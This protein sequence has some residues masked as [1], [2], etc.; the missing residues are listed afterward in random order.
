MKED[1][2]KYIDALRTKTPSQETKIRALSGGNQQKIVLGKELA[3][4]PKVILFDEPTRGIDVEAKRE[5]Y[6][7]MHE[8]A[9]QGVAVIMNSSDMMEVIGMSSRVIVMYEGRISG[10]LQKEELSEELIMQ[11]GMGMKKERTKEET[12]G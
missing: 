7:I 4:E 2:Q 3:T 6:Q 9:A 5:F 11:F 1:T 12:E 8:L 10:T